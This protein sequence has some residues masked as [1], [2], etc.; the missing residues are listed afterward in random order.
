LVPGI[1]RIS[2]GDLTLE[3]ETSMLFSNLGHQL[4]SNGAISLK[5]RVVDPAAVLFVVTFNF[6][7]AARIA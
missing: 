5:N 7:R 4:P 1:L 3:D 2:K 6:W